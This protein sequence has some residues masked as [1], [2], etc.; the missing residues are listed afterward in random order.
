MPLIILANRAHWTDFGATCAIDAG[1]RIN[2]VVLITLTDAFYR[3]FT[4]ASPAADAVSTDH[5]C[6]VVFAPFFTN[7][8]GLG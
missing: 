6:H 2:Y 7:L 5:M 8:P 3:A 1:I 4:S